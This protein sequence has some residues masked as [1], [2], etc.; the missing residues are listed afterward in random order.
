MNKVIRLKMR[1]QNQPPYNKP[2]REERISRFE[3]ILRIQTKEPSNKFEN[4]RFK[5][6]DLTNDIEINNLFEITK[7]PILFVSFMQ[8]PR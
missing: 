6:V 1:T 4:L 8:N 2:A 7:H 5:K 3:S